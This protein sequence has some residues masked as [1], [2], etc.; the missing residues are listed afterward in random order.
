VPE[1]FPEDL[2]HLL[3][4]SLAGY[5]DDDAITENSNA[6]TDT[7]VAGT[8]RPRLPW[9][10]HLHR[11][12]VI[13]RYSTT[14]LRVAYEEIERVAREEAEIG[15]D[16]RRLDAARRRLSETVVPWMSSVFESEFKLGWREGEG[17]MEEWRKGEGRMC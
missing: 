13:P 7:N 4:T 15:W 10:S 5:S 14:L 9:A 6:N 1:R 2:R 11:L 8:T 17:G 3:T 12:T 16:E